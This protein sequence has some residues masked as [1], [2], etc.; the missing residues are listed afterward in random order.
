MTLRAGRPE[1]FLVQVLMTRA[2]LRPFGGRIRLSPM[3]LPAGC[4]QMAPGERDALRMILAG[5]D[6]RLPG[7]RSMTGCA[8]LRRGSLLAHEAR[9]SCLMTAIA[10]GRETTKLPA[11]VSLVAIGA[12]QGTM[13]SQQWKASPL[14]SSRMGHLGEAL[15]IVT[16]LTALGGRIS[17]RIG[18][19]ALARCGETK[20]CSPSLPCW[21][22]R[23][24]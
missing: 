3:T 20:K 15:F 6:D 8:R 11:L 10:L 9:M 13:L 14:M 21:Q 17:M 18:M 22:F 19:A 7:S 16:A 24:G 2:A 12:G 5:E 4:F 1:F 23:D